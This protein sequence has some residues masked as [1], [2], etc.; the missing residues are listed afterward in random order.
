MTIYNEFSYWN[1]RELPNSADPKVTKIHIDFIKKHV[2]KGMTVLDYGPGVGRTFEAY[3]GVKCV[4]GYDISEKYAA[5]AVATAKALGLEY[6]H[7]ILEKNTFNTE[8]EYDLV[9]A[10][11]VFLHQRPEAVKEIIK[12]LSSIGKKVLIITWYDPN[13]DFDIRT[14]YQFCYNHDYLGMLEELGLKYEYA[15]DG[16]QLYLTYWRE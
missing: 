14:S 7:F 6:Q 10:C 9:V 15:T 5:E 4:S 11:S 1:D 2:K 12:D 8:D 13:R 16:N 3:K